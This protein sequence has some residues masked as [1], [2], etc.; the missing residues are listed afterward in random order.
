MKKIGLPQIFF[1]RQGG[2]VY[3]KMVIE[4]LSGHFDVE[5]MDFSSKIFKKIR[6][7]RIPESLIYLLNLKGKKDLWIRDFYSTIT[8]RKNRTIG[9]NL[10]LIFHVDFSGFPLLSRL[11]FYIL[12]KLLFYWQ[13]KRVDAIVT[14][15]EYW[16][17][18]FIERGYR[19][20]YK[21]YCGFDLNSFNISDSE[22]SDF[23]R[24]YN[25][26]YKPIVYLGN[27]Q[28]PKGALDSY[29]ALKDLNVHFVTSG[30]QR[31]KIPALNFDV[32]YREYLK[33]LKASTMA[34]TMSKFKEG[35]CMT[36]H[37]AML[38]KTPV[39]GSGMGGMKELLE[40]GKQIICTDFKEL[41][42]KVEYLLKNSEKREEI[43]KMGYNYAKD[44]TLER[45]K[46]EWLDL[47]NRV[48]ETEPR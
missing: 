34:I 39:I 13:L 19:N 47:I 11:P 5:S 25:L 40:G 36:T 42:N 1:K 6:Y 17:N 26:Q 16:K 37:E 29:R 30:K 4:T 41:R 43:G 20:V 44:F 46:K 45:F 35:W 28:K 21:I 10:S 33:L 8:L 24:K 14:I 23:K 7:L 22:V 31:V 3:R 9:K 32:G 12:E 38:C 48:L 15:S 18:Y 27:C 2:V